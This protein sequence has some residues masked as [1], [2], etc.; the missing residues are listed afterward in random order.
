MSLEGHYHSSLLTCFSDPCLCV[1]GFFCTPFLQFA[2]AYSLSTYTPNCVIACCLFIHP[3]AVRLEIRNK[4][5]MPLSLFTDCLVT[6]FC[7]PCAVIQDA[8][9]IN[10]MRYNMM[11]YNRPSSRQVSPRM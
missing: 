8:K 7:A 2:N 9:E 1:C 4:E 6:N 5:H 3:Y 10:H 11:R